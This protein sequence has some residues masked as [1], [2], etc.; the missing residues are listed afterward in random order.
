M[1]LRAIGQ[2]D[3]SLPHGKWIRR[4]A[5]HTL[6]KQSYQSD[7]PKDDGAWW[8]YEIGPAAESTLPRYSLPV[9]AIRLKAYVPQGGASNTDLDMPEEGFLA[10]KNMTGWLKKQMLFTKAANQHFK[11]LDIA[12][13]KTAYRITDYAEYIPIPAL[14]TTQF[15]DEFL[16]KHGT[17]VPKLKREHITVSFSVF[18]CGL[19]LV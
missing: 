6:V 13:S 3:E 10:K 8:R 15:T 17:T 18:G 5:V 1:D 19:T 4:T 14:D 16:A 12:A 7:A 11:H 9:V 2:N